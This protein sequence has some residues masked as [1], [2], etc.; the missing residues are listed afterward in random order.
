M[1]IGK[2]RGDNYKLVVGSLQPS[3]RDY[4]EVLASC[5]VPDLCLHLESFPQWVWD[6]SDI[7]CWAPVL[8]RF[9]DIFRSYVDSY[10]GYIKGDHDSIPSFYNEDTLELIKNAL[11]ASV[12]IVENSTS[13][14]IYNSVD[15]LVALLD[16]IHPDIV[17][18][19]TKLLCVYFSRQRRST[20]PKDIPEVSGR[21]AIL[22]QTPL[23]DSTCRVHM[24]KQH[25]SD[26]QI[27]MSSTDVSSS[28]EFDSIS[29]SDVIDY[30]VKQS[31]YYL[32]LESYV[33]VGQEVLRGNDVSSLRIPVLDI[34]CLSGVETSPRR[35][36]PEITSNASFMMAADTQKG[37]LTGKLDLYKH[38]VKA[39]RYVVKKYKV[40][41]G[42]ISELK[43]K[44]SKVYAMYYPFMQ[45]KLVE[46]RL[47]SLICM[48][49]MSNATFNQF[50]NYNPSFLLEISHMLRRHL[51][52]ERST[53]VITTELLSTMVYDGIHSRTL[54]SI[55][56]LNSPHGIFTKV[57]VYYLHHAHETEPL[58][59]LLHFKNE[60]ET[61]VFSSLSELLEYNNL[62]DTDGRH[63]KN[64]CNF[65]QQGCVLAPETC[66]KEWDWTTRLSTEEGRRDIQHH[67]DSMRI[68]LQLL[69][70]F[71]TTISYHGCTNALTNTS[72]LEGVVR[73]I[74][75]RDPI[76]LPVVIYV[77]QVL[78]ALLEYNQT[79]SRTLRKHLHVFHIFVSRL[80]YDMHIIEQS[81]PLENPVSEVTPWPR[82]WKIPYSRDLLTIRSYWMCMS[83][84]S[85]RRFLFKTMVRN[86]D[87]AA[88]SLTGRSES[89]DQDIFT[90]TS[91]VVPI[92]HAIFSKPHDYGLSAYSSAINLISDALGEDPI[93]QEELHNI[94]LIPALL[95]S[96]SEET[97]KYEDSLQIIPTAICDI[98]MHR[99]GQDWM[100][101]H[102]FAPVMKLI[103]IVVNKDFVLFDRF[104]EV[105]STIGAT[106]GTI[107]RSES[108]RV[109]IMNKL[110]KTMQKL[111]EE[112]H[113][114][115]AF[116]PKDSVRCAKDLE[117]SLQEFKTH[118]P[119]ITLEM[120]ASMESNSDD[121]FYADRIAHLGK[122]LSTYLS[123]VRP[124]SHFISVDG[125]K[126]LLQLCSVPCLP[127]LSMLI[128]SQ[129]PMA[130]VIKFIL[131]RAPTPCIT[132][133]HN[134]CRPYLRQPIAYGYPNTE[135]DL[136]NNM[137]YLKMFH[138][139][140][141]MF[142][143]IHREDSDF[144]NSCCNGSFQLGANKA[145]T[146]EMHITLSSYL[147]RVITEIPYLMQH[148]FRSTNDGDRETFFILS[149]KHLPHEHPQLKAYK[150]HNRDAK[151]PQNQSE[152][153][154][155][156]NDLFWSSQFEYAYSIPNPSYDG[157]SASE[158]S[159]DKFKMNTEVCRLCL[160]T[161]K[162]F[163]YALNATINKTTSQT[164]NC[165]PCSR[166]YVSHHSVALSLLCINMLRTIPSLENVNNPSS[167]LLP[168]M[169][170]MNTARFVAETMEMTYK[171]L[172]EDKSVKGLYMLSF[173]VFARM[174]GIGHI[175]KVLDYMIFMFLGCAV[176]MA[177]RAN[178]GLKAE[179]VIGSGSK[180]SPEPLMNVAEKM[181]DF[182]VK[183]IKY[184][185]D[186][187]GRS[188]LIC[189]ALFTK[190]CNPKTIMGTKYEVDIW[191]YTSSDAFNNVFPKVEGDIL[192][193]MS[194]CVSLI[195][196]TCWKWLQT[197]ASF[198]PLTPCNGT[199]NVHFYIA[200]KL[201]G[202][203]VK[204]HIYIMD[205]VTPQ[206][207][208]ALKAHFESHKTKGEDTDR[209][210]QLSDRLIPGSRSRRRNRMSGYGTNDTDGYGDRHG[211]VPTI[212]EA[213]N[214]LNDMGFSNRNV[215]RALEECGHTDIETLANWLLTRPDGDD[216]SDNEQMDDVIL[217]DA[218]ETPEESYMNSSNNNI[219]N[220]E[221]DLFSFKCIVDGKE[222][223]IWDMPFERSDGHSMVH[224][225]LGN[226]QTDIC[227]KLVDVVLSL[228]PKMSSALSVICD[229]MLR[230]F[231]FQAGSDGDCMMDDPED[232]H[233]T[234]I[235][236]IV[237]FIYNGLDNIF[238]ELSGMSIS[239]KKEELL[240]VF[241]PVIFMDDMEKQFAF[242]STVLANKAAVNVPYSC[243]MA[244]IHEQL[245]G[246][247][248]ILSQLIG[249]KEDYTSLLLKNM[250]NPLDIILKF[251]CFFQNMR[252][253]A[254]TAGTITFSG[255]GMKPSLPGI[256]ISLPDWCLHT[257]F[258]KTQGKD[259]VILKAKVDYSLTSY[260]FIRNLPIPQMSCVPP[261][262]KYALAC[263][264]ELLKKHS[265]I[266]LSSILASSMDLSK[267]VEILSVTN[268]MPFIPKST[269]K[270]LVHI[271]LNILECFPG[272]DADVIF[273]LLSILDSLT[274]AY[275]NALEVIN[276]K[277]LPL[278]EN[279]PTH[280]NTKV[281]FD[282]II[283]ADAFSIL[284]TIPKSG[285]CKGIL[286]L[287]SRIIMHCMENPSMLREAIERGVISFLSANEA[288]PV[289]L[290]VLVEKVYPFIKKDPA[291]LLKIL[292]KH[293]VLTLEDG[294][295][296]VDLCNACIDLRTS[297]RIT[298]LLKKNADLIHPGSIPVLA[299]SEDD[300]LNAPDHNTLLLSILRLLVIYMQILC[301]IHGV[302]RIGVTTGE[303]SKP[304]YPYALSVNS[305]FYILNT[306]C[307][308]FPIPI[309]N[310]KAPKLE[311]DMP[312]KPFPWR[313]NMINVG[314]SHIVLLQIVRRIFLM[315]CSLCIPQHKAQVSKEHQ[316][317]VANTQKL[318]VATL[319]SY[320]NSILLVSSRSMKMCVIMVEELKIMLLFLIGFNTKDC[321][322]NFLP[323]ATYTVCTMLYNLLQLRFN[324]SERVELSSEAAFQIKK[325]LVTL[326]RR[327]DLYKDGTSV[328][329]TALTRT[330]VL[331]TSPNK[332]GLSTIGNQMEA[333]EGVQNYADNEEDI[334]EIDIALDVDDGSYDSEEDEDVSISS[335]EEGEYEGDS[336][337][338]ND[339]IEDAMDEDSASYS[340]EDE[341]GTAD[342]SDS[343]VENIDEHYTSDSDDDDSSVSTE[344]DDLDSEHESD[345]GHDVDMVLPHQVDENY[346][347][348]NHS[349]T[350]S[351][352]SMDEIDD[353]ED[354]DDA[355]RIRV[356]GE[357]D[358]ESRDE[359]I[360][361]VIEENRSHLNI[362]G[363]DENGIMDGSQ[364]SSEDEEFHEN[365]GMATVVS[366]AGG[367]GNNSL[368]IN[369]DDP[370]VTLPGTGNNGIRIQIE[371]SNH[372]R[373]WHEIESSSMRQ[374]TQM[375][376]IEQ[377]S[378][379]D[380]V[381]GSSRANENAESWASPG[382]LSIPPKHPMLPSTRKSAGPAL[383]QNGEIINLITL[384]LPTVQIPKAATEGSDSH[385]EDRVVKSSGERS[386]ETRPIQMSDLAVTGEE[387]SPNAQPSYF[388]PQIERLAENLGL[389]YEDIFTLASM[390]PTVIGEL[391][392]DM[393]EE[394]ILQQL[395]TI[396]IEALVQLRDT[397]Q[398]TTGGDGAYSSQD[399]RYI[400]YVETLPRQLRAQVIRSLYTGTNNAAAIIA[401]S[402]AN[403]ADVTGENW[404]ANSDRQRL[405]DVITPF[406][407]EQLIQGATQAF[408]EALGTNRVG[409]RSSARNRRNTSNNET[410]GEVNL[411][412]EES[413]APNEQSMMIGSGTSFNIPATEATNIPG[414]TFGVIIGD[415]TDRNSMRGRGGNMQRG[416]NNNNNRRF[417]QMPPR[418]RID[419]NG[420][421]GFN[422]GNMTV[423]NTNG[424]RV[425][426]PDLNSM[427][428]VEALPI[429]V[430][431]DVDAQVVNIQPI[432]TN[433]SRR[434]GIDSRILR[435]LPH[436][437]NTFQ[438]HFL[439]MLQGVNRSSSGN[440]QAQNVQV[441]DGTISHIDNNIDVS[442][443]N[444]VE[445]VVNVLARS[446]CEVPMAPIGEDSCQ[447]LDTC[448][449]TKNEFMEND[450]V[451]IC[452]LMYLKD[453]INKK[454]YFKLL[455][456]LS[457]S[458]NDL[459][460]LLMKY[461]LYIIHTSIIALSHT[462][463]ST[464]RSDAFFASLPRLYTSRKDEFPPTHLYGSLP[465]KHTCLEGKADPDSKQPLSF[466]STSG[467]NQS[468]FNGVDLHS[469]SASYVAC[470]RV[471]EQ[472]RSLMIALPAVIEFFG[473][474]I[475]ATAEEDSVSP[476]GNQT[477][478]VK[479]VSSAVSAVRNQDFYPIGFLFMAT[480]TKLFQSS[481]KLM[482][483][484]LMVIHHLVVRT[485]SFDISGPLDNCAS[486]VESTNTSLPG[487]G[488]N[489]PV[490]QSQQLEENLLGVN[491]SNENLMS[492]L[493][494]CD[495][496]SS[497]KEQ[498]R[499][500]QVDVVDNIDRES[501][502][503]F[504]DVHSSWY[505]QSNWLNTF[506]SSRDGA[507]GT[508][509]HI[510]ARILAAL[511]MNSKH[512]A[513]VKDFFVTRISHLNQALCQSLVTVDIANSN[514]L[515]HR[516][517]ALLRI[518]TLVND[519]FGESYKT[520]SS[521]DSEVIALKPGKMNEFY[522]QI[523]FDNL[524]IGLDM[525]LTN[526]MKHSGTPS[527]S[528]SLNTVNGSLSSLRDS[529]IENSLCV[530]RL[531]ALIPLIEVFMT[532]T[533]IRV[534][535]DY[536][537]EDVTELDN[538]MSFINF[539]YELPEE[540]L[541][542]MAVSKQE[543]IPHKKEPWDCDDTSVDISPNH[544]SLIY[545][546]EKHSRAF[547]CLIKQT[548]SLL[549]S[550]FIGIVRLAPN[551][552]TFAVKRQYFR[553]KLKEYRQ[554]P[555]PD[556]VRIN[557]R[558]EHVFLDS[559][560]QLRLRSGEEMKGRLAVSFTG[561]EG[562]DAG[563]LTRE[564]FSILAKEMF[565]PNYGLFR[566]EGRKQEFNH[567]NPLSGINPDHLNF[568]KFIGR[569]IGKAVY[570]GQHIDA[571]FCRSFYKH[572]LC[573]KITPADAESVDP[574][575]YENL[576]SINNCRLED[577]GLELFFST[578]IDEFGKVKVIDLIPDGRNIHVTDENK[579]KYIELLC[580]H[581]VT[582]G[583]KDQLDAF[584]SGFQELISPELIS[585]FDDK[586]LE[587]LIS[588]I[589]TI[590]LSDLRENVEYVNY[591]KESEQI[592]WLWEF[593]EGLDQNNVAAFLQFVTGTSRVPIG[594]FKHL[595]G[596]RG[597]Q[598]ISIHRTYGSERLPSAHTC[599]NQ[600]DLPAYSSR[601]T[602]HQKMMQAILEGKEGFGF[603]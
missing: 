276:Y 187:F 190:I 195:G 274:E 312:H 122:C 406:I 153:S 139:I 152:N 546:T 326:L 563:G 217:I 213:R 146:C 17:F 155:S 151:V 580:R 251:V 62:S 183:K 573:R 47:S 10:K 488:N 125:L 41:D 589:P 209:S 419:M 181:R 220:K 7:L 258:V 158:L 94:G 287:V 22:S 286:K 210:M 320:T 255:I 545:F 400:Y 535:L 97:L 315:I 157:G 316:Q 15:V 214:T 20:A 40:E 194:Q 262:F 467:S 559:Y 407:R 454:I 6:K 473:R 18:L 322:V 390:D 39:L 357:L 63:E 182:D 81:V 9:D 188:V 393:R 324:S 219:L 91:P 118:S 425:Q 268:N 184:T 405:V 354:D 93:V 466:L 511:Y 567:P 317:E 455:Y 463:V 292:N 440:M 314:D 171:L 307:A 410:G 138:G 458:D 129:H 48:L 383:P 192:T 206:R 461:F 16:D 102:E 369:I 269:Q 564:W 391:P 333:R 586:E 83:S 432:G 167:F 471:L 68:L 361:E 362:A 404:E 509:M 536:L 421:R 448:R 26:D 134:I 252:Y 124:V 544:L 130:M 170:C 19:A 368:S 418:R 415:F 189:L 528:D 336:E 394:I 201:I 296:K 311:L 150:L 478:R 434:E 486:I 483:H 74:R 387:T 576:T 513:D 21:I 562:I 12:M 539:D 506:S 90:P 489:T 335:Q 46:I 303:G 266:G 96:I 290:I 45:R 334:D 444:L 60:Q 149:G 479:T 51:E 505:H 8:N 227:S 162:A 44:M 510:V 553:Q 596:M 498:A 447:L 452:K 343:D 222:D 453:E 299:A 168:G 104:G 165:N 439:N 211:R 512:S 203:I 291:M 379:V 499:T 597:P 426:I 272:A 543:R 431:G 112:A 402:G 591:T 373:P 464:I 243:E 380:G 502:R 257:E 30:Y 470:E 374:P 403:V 340:S 433:R 264:S 120:L 327:L 294:A 175:V 497:D 530:E 98:L 587:L 28:E 59:P 526:A 579:H 80:Q 436:L 520:H 525:A 476:S 370:T 396:D 538:A 42:Y 147:K 301:N 569:V 321:G 172:T 355:P 493:P 365:A 174:S 177:M 117:I 238:N 507:S 305:L 133:L 297:P 108:S 37:T 29:Y 584:M 574:Q 353:E 385:S 468:N 57:L 416:R 205:F 148:F 602:L 475:T 603:I 216:A 288:E 534:A 348:S 270:K 92:L 485:P 164:L 33:E 142:Y 207:Q 504:L 364:I 300:E 240:P 273:A 522:R 366:N 508:H 547:N 27:E 551:C 55:L 330:L 263:I 103:D 457:A 284:L 422:L 73:F 392:E 56:G 328:L 135:E 325:C 100:R 339:Y 381:T 242:D 85:A 5:S 582:N 474:Q 376:S 557:V 359:V 554:G 36:L 516:I 306:V 248:Y 239:M 398:R 341:N 363:H 241:C 186:I 397:R 318:V 503:V 137:E 69:I 253:E 123:F 4:I 244:K 565:N 49:I 570:D 32:T 224:A 277:R 161:S 345:G 179:D 121:D 352:S 223:D 598:R 568:F 460:H 72:V 347:A 180:I 65:Q 581:K 202:S 67:E 484:L 592:V 372:D 414:V 199:A 52:L 225:D 566:R 446:V 191:T 53:M 491:K 342:D 215:E 412:G 280:F 435:S 58:P 304:G 84:M 358:E 23:P 87:T 541:D 101:R 555:R 351:H 469:N 600:L 346:H 451:G 1:K 197:I 599:F 285:E 265:L 549:S 109:L 529:G 95:S 176:A 465:Y 490:D 126:L 260:G 99:S 481:P 310:N 527:L 329:C 585:I 521:A 313:V 438:P 408:M 131:G 537:L 577:L 282:D 443:D 295:T 548:P 395:G 560:H 198:N 226:L 3:Q 24:T 228:I 208:E 14:S 384:T 107:S 424:N 399:N 204:V 323:L 231:P 367:G 250:R 550:S 558:R 283:G 86:I 459:C 113:R 386:P 588:G 561:E 76:Y 417:T 594:G 308:N 556:T 79:V 332:A 337:E 482:N 409:T 200:N 116:G 492:P 221:P 518:V 119:A 349:E 25:E 413:D 360:A 233:V 193:L 495:P 261:F 218:T 38:M 229:S 514:E 278:Q 480:A 552:L 293:C 127:P 371:I 456:N 515:E 496:R 523:N 34:L 163:L 105:A 232:P 115:P 71:Y 247:F 173:V 141:Y 166:N 517:Q 411:N 61:K 298:E 259:K 106:L 31:Q 540:N 78:E 427:D 442:S 532:I 595:M 143:L 82:G 423:W 319:A 35:A 382:D 132:Y 43:Y 428:T 136:M 350:S 477:K 449:G 11:K 275:P 54:T 377:I 77:V 375:S 420:G 267:N 302:T 450:I 281:E 593:L 271:C 89:H 144:Y 519:M 279:Y 185:M 75:M 601:E 494:R 237:N 2:P 13:K 246:L 338:I 437:F 531:N 236:T 472:L 64:T 575:F 462:S 234:H 356:V 254:H 249:G 159:D 140:S 178:P 542:F 88:R 212:E 309:N 50:L 235:L 169:D 590:D 388:N 445:S 70:V 524:W 110:I 160:V 66:L 487:E 154:F 571:Y 401:S 196:V 430:P 230:T 111:L 501:V 156:T 389:L 441:S 344:S 572:M 578:E 500:E 331:V 114:Y 256:P 533:Q 378:H 128:Y 245:L 583:I 429:S 289:P 145:S